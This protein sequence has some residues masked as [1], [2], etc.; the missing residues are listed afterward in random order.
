MWKKIT[1]KRGGSM[2][3]SRKVFGVSRGVKTPR[4]ARLL[5][6]G[7][8]QGLSGRVSIYSD[9]NGKIAFLDTPNGEYKVTASTKAAKHR[10]VNIPAEF[11]PMIPYGTTD[12]DVTEEGGMIVVDTAQFKSRLVAE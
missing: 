11:V 12:I 5:V 8:Y 6:P 4:T 1:R 9:G 10:Q 7:S 3:A 2:K